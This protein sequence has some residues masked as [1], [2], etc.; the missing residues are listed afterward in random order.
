MAA[1]ELLIFPQN[2]LIWF[3][4][5]T[6]TLCEWCMIG[7]RISGSWLRNLSSAGLRQH[8]WPWLRPGIDLASTAFA[9]LIVFVLFALMGGFIA[10]ALPVVISIAGLGGEND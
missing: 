6:W 1:I 9:Y 3:V 2:A 8:P 10:S 5:E 4:R 7:S